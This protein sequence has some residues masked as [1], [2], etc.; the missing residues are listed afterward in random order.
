MHADLLRFREAVER[1]P[2]GALFIALFA[3][4]TDLVALSGHFLAVVVDHFSVT[5][6]FELK[7]RVDKRPISK[8]WRW[9]TCFF[10]GSLII[11]RRIILVIDYYTAG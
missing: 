3:R 11:G 5:Q 6:R 7:Y 4:W 8:R 1:V 2:L 10:L 9:L